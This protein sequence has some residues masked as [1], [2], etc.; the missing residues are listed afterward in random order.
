M[1]SYERNV[2]SL[3]KELVYLEEVLKNLTEDEVQHLAREK[4][5]ETQFRDTSIKDKLSRP[6]NKRSKIPEI[7][8]EHE[9]ENG[10][11]IQTLH[12]GQLNA[13]AR[14]KDFY[15]DLYNHQE[16]KDEVEDIKEFLGNAQIPQVTEEENRKITAEITED[17]V[18]DYI[19]TLNPNKAP[20]ISGLR[21]GHF[22]EI[23]PYAGKIITKAINEC[24]EE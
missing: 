13:Q 1:D 21:S 11:T 20:G 23:W 6:P 9:D 7:I 22:L 19:K 15:R 18:L 8:T 14:I 17:E 2:P 24:L 10:K 12:K 5:K 3:E 16:C 4:A